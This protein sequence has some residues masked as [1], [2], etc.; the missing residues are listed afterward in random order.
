VR[1]IAEREEYEREVLLEEI[2][3][4]NRIQI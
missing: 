3:K 1:V 4:G 2:R